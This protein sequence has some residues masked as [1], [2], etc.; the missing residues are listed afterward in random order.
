MAFFKKRRQSGAALLVILA[1]SAI[2][3]PLIQGVWLDTQIEYKFTRYRMNELQARYNAKSGIGLSLLRVYIFK[4][5]EKSLP[6]GQW[7]SLVRPLLDKIWSFPFVWPLPIMEEM[8]SSEKEEIQN[9]MN[10]SFF[11]G[12]YGVSIAPEDGRLDINDLSSPL[13]SLREF[14]Y[15]TLLNFLLNSIENKSELKDKYDRKDIEEILNNLS[16]W[17]DLDN[18]SQNGGSEELL[19]EGKKPLNR[20]FISVEEIKKTPGMSAEIYEILNPYITVHGAKA[21]NINYASGEILQALNIPEG[22][23]EEVLS[24]TQ[25]SSAYYEPFL[26]QQTFCDFIE[27]L[28]FSFCPE[29]KERYKTLD[30]LTFDYPMAFRIKS[31]GEYRGNLVELEALLYDLSSLALTYQKSRY[32]QIQRKKEENKQDLPADSSTNGKNTDQEKKTQTKKPKMDYSYYKSLII[33][34]LKENF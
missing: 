8:L 13:V 31:S 10:Q 18:D 7:S 1:V 24:R 3:I 9:I 2:L 30:M 20:S 26:N 21:L 6:E 5:V 11:K 17:T 4:G 32:N 16:D 33:M 22:L 14:T 28:G 25:I 19:E 29:F 15:E 27:K 12:V 23:V 34:Y